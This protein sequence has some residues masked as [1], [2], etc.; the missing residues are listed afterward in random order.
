MDELVKT[1]DDRE[2]AVVELWRKGHLC[3]GTIVVYL[4]WMRRFRKYCDKRKLPEI[5]QL[6]A[7]GVQRFTRA[8]VGPRLR[9]RL[10]SRNSCNLANNA[11]HAWACALG[12]LGIPLPPW[13]DKRAPQLSPLL[14]EY[15]HYRR[16][17]NGV[18][19][20]TLVRDVETARGFLG[21]LRR[22]GKSIRLAGLVD[23]DMFVRELSTRVSKRTVVD[24]C[25][26]LRAFLRFLKMT[27]RLPADLAG[28]VIRTTIPNRRAASAHF[29][30]DVNIQKW[31]QRSD[32]KALKELGIYDGLHSPRMTV[33]L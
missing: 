2:R 32:S 21:Q 30:M 9:G 23:V 24:T 11:L 25:S 7:A 26:S 29:A 3:L 18:S 10:S 20:G 17:H 4:H 14:K 8:Y 16:A 1:N 22:E 19:D 31:R 13:H 5:E 12:A 6:T 15:C 33:S 28:G 27:G